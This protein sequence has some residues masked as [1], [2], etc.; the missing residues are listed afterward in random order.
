M[1]YR[2]HRVLILA[3]FV[4]L[5]LINF[6]FAQHDHHEDDAEELWNPVSAGPLTAWTAPLCGKK[7]F[8]VQPFLFYNRTRGT[9]NTEGRYD[10]LAQG[11]KKYQYQQQIFM[12]YGLTDKW[13]IDGQLTYQQNYIKQGGLK[14]HSRGLTD[15]YLF[16][17]YCAFE[18]TNLLPHITSLLQLKLPTAK[19]RNLDSNKLGT[20]AMGAASG[21]GSF[22]F[23]SGFN[24]TKK[25]K[26]FVFHLDAIYSF[27]Q[28]R[29]IDSVKTKYGRYLNYDFGAEYFFAKNTNLMLEFNGFL[30]GDKTENG[31]KTP[32]S[33]I[34]YLNLA[35]GIGWSNPKLQML[36]AYQRSLV[37]I[38][39]DAND[40]VAFT[41]VRTF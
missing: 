18:E 32:A 24:L 39:T 35:T 12:Q 7:K 33:N 14:A 29:K 34:N 31:Q 8:V 10:S 11:D 21:G 37:G 2:I 17:R 20:D 41:L 30:Q 40:S 38:N 9:F 26:P 16:L 25:F 13:E 1:R 5:A 27:P 4:F 3:A 28:E 19:F 6:S 23:G 22:D 36:L 15:S